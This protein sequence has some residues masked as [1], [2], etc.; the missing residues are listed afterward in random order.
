MMSIKHQVPCKVNIIQSNEEQQK[1]HPELS[2]HPHD[3]IV[4]MIIIVI[5]LY[6]LSY[7]I[8]VPIMAP[9][10]RDYSRDPAGRL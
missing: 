4:L 8:L 7:I 1:E 5:M 2:S 3:W 6:A 10:R 9:R